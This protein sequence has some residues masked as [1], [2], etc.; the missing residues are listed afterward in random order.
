MKKFLF[1]LF[2]LSSCSATTT[3]NGKNTIFIFSE[4]LSINQFK[5]KLENYVKNNPYPNIDD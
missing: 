1:L 2:F 3:D 4:Q 5:L